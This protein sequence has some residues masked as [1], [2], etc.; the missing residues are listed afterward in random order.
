MGHSSTLA[1][2]RNSAKTGRRQLQALVRQRLNKKSEEAAHSAPP[3]PWLY[4][5]PKRQ[6]HAQ[7]PRKSSQRQLRLGQ[8]RFPAEC[9]RRALEETI[10]QGRDARACEIG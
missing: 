7:K 3:S 4:D 2:K 1:H 9:N 10:L 8:A 5:T 6:P